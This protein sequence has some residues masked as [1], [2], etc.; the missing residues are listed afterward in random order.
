VVASYTRYQDA[1]R[2][3]D[4][5]ADRGFPVEHVSIVGRDLQ[6]V[7]QVTGRL[8]Y[9]E[10]TI[11]GTAIGGVLG[12]ALGWLFGIFDWVHPL[13]SGALLAVYGLVIG[14][15]W[16]AVTGALGHWLAHGRHDYT[17]V[18]GMRAGRYDVLVDDDVA[19]SAIRVLMELEDAQARS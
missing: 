3:V 10:A 8:G 5:L 12:A 2:A 13:V 14:A 7:E 15:A 17:S 16:G 19:D 11:R 18:A 9:P 1:Q 6:F 4:F